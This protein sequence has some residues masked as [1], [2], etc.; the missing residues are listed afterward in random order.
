MQIGLSPRDQFFKN[1]A[2]HLR[3]YRYFNIQWSALSNGEIEAVK[4]LMQDSLNTLI[5]YTQRR[6]VI[7]SILFKQSTIE[8]W[9]ITDYLL[10]KTVA[11]DI[12]DIDIVVRVKS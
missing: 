10:Q 6:I 11:I 9:N 4:Q 5:G 2:E 7:L 8:I 12:N 1:L 3:V